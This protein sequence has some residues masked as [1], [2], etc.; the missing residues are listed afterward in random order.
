MKFIISFFWICSI[1]LGSQL[2]NKGEYIFFAKS[3]S[4]CHGPEAKGTTTAPK[5]AHKKQTYLLQRL[6]NFKAG[7]V[8]TQKQEMMSQFV[9]KLSNDDLKA[10]SIFLSE[11]KEKKTP[12]VADDLLGGFGS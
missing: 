12:E 9:Q 3:C 2:Y 10:L 7:K 4:S 1:L 5:L 6:Q 11:I 8:Y